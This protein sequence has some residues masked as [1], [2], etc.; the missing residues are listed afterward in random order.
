MTRV[1]TAIR[2]LHLRLSDLWLRVIASFKL[3]K[4]TFL[5]LAAIAAY[6]ML[7]PDTAQHMTRW[8]MELAADHHYRVLDFIVGHALELDPRTLRLLGVGS[9]VYAALF[10]VEGFGLYYD[11]RW[12]EYMTIVTTA[13]LIPFEIF[14]IARHTTSGKIAVLIGNILIVGY[15]AWRVNAKLEPLSSL[16]LSA[17][18]NDSEHP[19]LKG[20]RETSADVSP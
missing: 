2:P 3:V 6:G 10:Y 16:A 1:H 20:R 19:P 14:E 11:K 17:A 8:A 15:L 4:A 12:A 18:G 13:G 5:L 7:N 9:L